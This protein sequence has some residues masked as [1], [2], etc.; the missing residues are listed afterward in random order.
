MELIDRYLQSIK[1]ALPKAQQNDVYDF[2]GRRAGN[3]QRAAVRL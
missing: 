3:G 2:L 1:L